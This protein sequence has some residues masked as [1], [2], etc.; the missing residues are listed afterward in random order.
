MRTMPNQVN[1]AKTVS[2]S[3]SR[4]T[5]RNIAA[6]DFGTKNCSL[7]YILAGDTGRGNDNT[8]KLPLNDNQTRV[9]TAILLDRDKRVIRFGAFAKEKYS[10]LDAAEK[11]NVYFFDGI[12]V[13]LARDKVCY[14][15]YFR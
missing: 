11:E 6:I 9:P 5:P 2:R 4:R 15:L 13:N 7:A 8:N 1:R 10:E 3:R 14:S 12:K